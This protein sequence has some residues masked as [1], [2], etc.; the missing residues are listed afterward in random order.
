M[1]E[2]DLGRRDWIKV[3]IGALVG[4]A[5]PSLWPHLAQAEPEDGARLDQ[6]G[7]PAPGLDPGGQLGQPGDRPDITQ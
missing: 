6:P 7:A 5:M 2:R 4:A 3:G 1:S